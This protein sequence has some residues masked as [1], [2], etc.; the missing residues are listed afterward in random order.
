[1]VKLG[2]FRVHH[3]ASPEYV[4]RVA[5]HVIRRTIVIDRFMLDVPAV[6]GLLFGFCIV[7]LPTVGSEGGL[8]LGSGAVGRFRPSTQ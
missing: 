2:N 1:M 4:I 6:K 3:E 7:C 8:R 5:V